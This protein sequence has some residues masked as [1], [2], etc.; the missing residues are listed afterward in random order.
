MEKIEIENNK[1]EDEPKARVLLSFETDNS[2]RMFGQDFV[3]TCVGY[4]ITSFYGG[5]GSAKFSIQVLEVDRIS[6]TAVVQTDPK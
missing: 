2:L 5:L 4:A 6:R 1:E 3:E